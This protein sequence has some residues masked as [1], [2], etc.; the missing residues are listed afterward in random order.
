MLQD[1]RRDEVLS[2]IVE[3]YNSYN[4]FCILSIESNDVLVPEHHTVLQYVKCG[5]MS[6]LYKC[7]AVLKNLC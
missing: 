1:L 5:Y 3:C 7:I 4:F 6:E 2:P